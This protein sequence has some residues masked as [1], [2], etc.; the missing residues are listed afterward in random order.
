[1]KATVCFALVVLFAV[2][3]YGQDTLVVKNPE[4]AG[5][6]IIRNVQSDSAIAVSNVTE[7]LWVRTEADIIGYI[8]HMHPVLADQHEVLIETFF[9][10]N[11]TVQLADSVGPLSFTPWTPWKKASYIIAPRFSERQGSSMVYRRGPDETRYTWWSDTSALLIFSVILG[12]VVAWDIFVDEDFYLLSVVFFGILLPGVLSFV[13]S[14]PGSFWSS[15][16]AALVWTWTTVAVIFLVGYAMR[17]L[18]QG[19]RDRLPGLLFA[20]KQKLSP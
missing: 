9:S 13:C 14:V 10:E 17:V 11:G 3:A 1:M 4:V 20:I 8:E 16:G 19:F 18:F 7:K 6:V 5:W 15:F 2:S 12:I